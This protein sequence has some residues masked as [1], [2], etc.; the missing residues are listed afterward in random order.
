MPRGPVRFLPVALLLGSFN[1]ESFNAASA[2]I[3]PHLDPSAVPAGCPACHVGHGLASSPMLGKAQQQVCLDCHGSQAD[4]DRAVS[5]GRLAAN[6]RPL[7]LS[8]NMAQPYTHPMTAG[9][10]SG[11]QERVVT[12]SSCHSPHRSTPFGRSGN[13]ATGT[14]CVSP[15][16]PSRFEFELCESCHGNAGVTTQNR[17]DV[18]RLFAPTNQSSHPVEGPSA[19]R[20]P[21]V[22]PS[23]A[24]REI[25][26]TDCH[27]SDNRAGPRGIHGSGVK[28]ILNASYTTS[29]GG[30]ESETAFALCY[31]CHDRTK[32]LKSSAFPDH[33][34]H[35]QEVKASCATCHS[36]HGSIGNRALIH[37]GEE[38]RQGGVSPSVK[39]NRFAYVS[40]SPGSGT[41]YLTCHGKDHGPEAYGPAKLYLRMR[42]ARPPGHRDVPQ[43]SPPD[44]PSPRSRSSE[45]PPPPPDHRFRKTP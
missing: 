28:N 33:G 2:S 38:T 40:T 41:C 1:L 24:G 27:G 20:S 23:L 21:S 29:D 18:S 45:A 22:I 42:S 32:I 30:G 8:S 12:C 34:R 7:L 36:A 3:N 44:I 39:A 10:L 11:R 43:T 5:S 26:C 15:K 6:R 25:N 37:F 17:T 9:A 19:G 16:D 14:R 35:I 4:Q 13:V 31:A